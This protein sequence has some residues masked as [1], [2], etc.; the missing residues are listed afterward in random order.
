VPVLV[1]A[2][3]SPPLIAEGSWLHGLTGALAWACFVAGVA[4]RFWATLYIGG[5]KECV[6]VVE[7][8]YSICRHPLYV[9]S[10]L[11]GVSATLFFESPSMLVALL[12]VAAVYMHAT[13]PIEE[14]VLRARH[15]DAF[16]AYAAVV[17]RWW[18]RRLHVRTPAE[19]SVDVRKLWLECARAS[20]WAWLPAVG[21]ALRHVRALAWL[22]RLLRVP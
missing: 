18:P 22:P 10:L 3:L 6:L 9:G 16:A 17:P 8:P 1:M 21:L 5:R 11:L 20:R 14:A 7:G 2:L 12:G 15:P 4:L 19:I 13:V